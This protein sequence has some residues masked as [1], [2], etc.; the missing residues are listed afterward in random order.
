M[1]V[2]PPPFAIPLFDKSGN[3]DLAW[4]RYFLQIQQAT[5]NVDIT[6]IDHG[7][8]GQTTKTA[9]LAALGGVPETRVVTAGLGLSGGGTLVTNR[10]FDVAGNLATL[11][12]LPN[13][14]GW[15]HNSGV[16]VLAYTTPT[17]A[18]V[19]AAPTAHTQNASTVLV[20]GGVGTPSYDDLQDVLRM[21]RSAGRLT[22]GTLSV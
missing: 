22:G 16:G 13:A 1:S 18:E 9:A 2:Q 5:A 4:Q 17:A 3:I 12:A 11:Y 15:L 10:T 14:A 8:T 21:T 7:G 20:P 6:Q 19:G